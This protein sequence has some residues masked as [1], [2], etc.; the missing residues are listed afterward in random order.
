MAAALAAA[1]VAVVPSVVDEAGNVDGLPNSLLEALAAGRPVV[2]T[3]VGGIPDVVEDGANGI[4]VP[5]KDPAALATALER[6]ARDPETRAR[7]GAEA[8]R[9][10]ESTLTWEAAAESFEDCY[11]QAAAL[12]AR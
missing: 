6:L 1:D 3:R 5:G 10:A 7:L 12:D 11:A 8:R 2:A 4:L 9:R